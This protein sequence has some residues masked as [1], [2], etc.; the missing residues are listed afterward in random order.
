MTRIMAVVLTDGFS[1][2]QAIYHMDDGNWT[3]RPPLNK[4][5]EAMAC[6]TFLVDYY[7]RLPDIMVFLQ[8]HLEGWPRA[9]H[10]DALHYSNVNSVRSLRLDYVPPAWLCQYA[11][12]ACPWV[13]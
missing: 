2:Q 8:P 9:W 12:S 3:F 5:R 6:L 7:D 1:W 11:M 4:G 10:I 13:P